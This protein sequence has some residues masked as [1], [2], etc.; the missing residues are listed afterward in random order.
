MTSGV[1]SVT[2]LVHVSKSKSTCL[3]FLVRV[4][5]S[6]NLS[7]NNLKRGGVWETWAQ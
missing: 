7:T 3:I 6:I 1:F 2:E 5:S 4:S